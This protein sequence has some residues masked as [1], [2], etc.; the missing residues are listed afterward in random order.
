MITK[1]II[2]NMA[3]AFQG[4]RTADVMGGALNL[5]VPQKISGSRAQMVTSHL[6]QV[7][8]LQNPETPKMFTGYELPYGVYTDSYIKA[9]GSLK[10]VDVIQ[11]FP[12]HHGWS[13]TYVVQDLVTGIYDV[14]EISHVEKLSEMHGYLRPMSPGDMFTPG[15][16]IPAGTTI[17]KSNNHDEFGNYRFGFN[18]KVC[19]M[20]L[21]EVEEDAVYICESLADRTRFTTIESVEITQNINDVLQNI[22]GDEE[23]YK[24][25]PD[26]GEEVQNGIVAAR[27]KIDY[28]N[29]ASEMTTSASKELRIDDTVFHGRGKVVDIDIHV[30]D[31]NELVNAKHRQQIMLYYTMIRGYYER[32]QNTLG[33]IKNKSNKYTYRLVAL[34]QR[35]KDY[36]DEDV[37][38]SSSNGVFEFARIEITMAASNPLKKGYKLT[39]R[40]GAKGVI[41][42]VVPDEMMPVDE[43]GVRAEMVLSP[44]GIPS[45][46]N[47]SQNYEHEMNFVADHVRRLMKSV[48]SIEKRFKLVLK[49]LNR[50]NKR[51]AKDYETFWSTLSEMERIIEMK[52]VEDEGIYIHQGPFSDN[53]SYDD[54]IALYDD[55]GVKPGII[56]SRREFRSAAGERYLQTQTWKKPHYKKVVDLHVDHEFTYGGDEMSFPDS[57]VIDGYVYN[58]AFHVPG[59]DGKTSIEII[60]TPL[61]SERE[62]PTQTTTTYIDEKG[63]F[64]REF[65]GQHRVVIADKYMLVLKHIPEG[66]FSARSLGTT[67]PIG[68]PNKTSKTEVGGPYSTTPIKFG[69]MELYNALIRVHPEIVHRFVASMATNPGIRVRLAEMLLNEDPARSHNLP[70][71]SEHIEDD[72]PVREIR[73]LMFCIGLEIEQ[74]SH[75]K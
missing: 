68:L 42:C 34:L 23:N 1:G 72:I 74:L 37:K 59:E 67:N 63:R 58:N 50:V 48:T 44:P 64:M 29:I 3:Q 55:W 62:L 38:F 41:S 75:Q 14:Y 13:Y 66:K 32:L 43:Y 36:L 27:R 60:S 4:D 69:E 12:L 35:A 52:E 26:L 47:I 16:V 61:V 28:K 49:F 8:M 15:T 6:E 21:S 25:F 40:C 54:M 11:K 7:V 20:S 73:A 53:I 33:K 56:R 10:V 57:E 65:Q 46:A 17:V 18:A 22:Y 30:N 2:E 51:E 24:P 39:D 9:P 70:I 19:Y 5:T 31:K 71:R 45:R